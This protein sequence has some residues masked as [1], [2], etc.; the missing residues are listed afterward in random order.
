M[1][2]TIIIDLGLVVFGGAGMLIWLNFFTASQIT[3]K[4][5]K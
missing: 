1:L 2:K 4:K 3:F 5:K